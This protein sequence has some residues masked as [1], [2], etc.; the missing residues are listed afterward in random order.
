MIPFFT[1]SVLFCED[2]PLTHVWL[3]GSVYMGRGRVVVLWVSGIPAPL[4]TIAAF[5]PRG[6]TPMRPLTGFIFIHS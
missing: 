3:C 4:H 2:G 6:R 5:C 1:H